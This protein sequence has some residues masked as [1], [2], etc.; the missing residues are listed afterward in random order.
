M[1]SYQ[2]QVE[3]VNSTNEPEINVIEF[4]MTISDLIEQYLAS[5]QQGSVQSG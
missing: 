5:G 4:R 2:F 1:S 3:I